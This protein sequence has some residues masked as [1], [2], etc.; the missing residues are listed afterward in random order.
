MKI[1]WIMNMA[2]PEIAEV[3]S[4]PADYGGGW[5]EQPCRQIATAHELTI[6]FPLDEELLPAAGE[7]NGIRYAAIPF[8]ASPEQLNS[9]TEQRITEIITTVNPDVIQIWGTEYLHSY[10]AFC[11][12]RKLGLLSRTLVYIQ[13]LVSVYKD[14]Y[15]GYIK[16]SS[17]RRPT[18]KDRLR[19][20]GPNLEY[21]DFFRRSPYEIEM[22][23]QTEHVI[24]RTDWDR[25]FA[26]LYHPGVH[27]HFCNETLRP[28]F[29]EGQWSLESCNRHR[30]FVSQSSYPVK[31]L[32][33]A[34]ES[35]YRLLP[36]YPDIMLYC[37]GKNRI[38]HSFHD[39]IRETRYDRYLRQ[40]IEKYQL[41]NHVVFTDKLNA[42]QMKEQYLHAHIFLSA[43]SIENSPNSVGEAM[44]LGTPVVSSDV[45]GVASMLTNEQE[46][47]LYQADRVDQMMACIDRIFTD[48]Q[49]ALRLSEQARR[50]AA[51]THDPE[52]NYRQMLAIYEEVTE[53]AE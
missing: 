43:S 39:I 25:H 36:K 40:L 24:G 23:E 31:G 42:E 4:L 16:D 45:G 20:T 11:V 46:G 7:V 48:D 37:T 21:E 30:I 28:A 3:L 1:L 47:L 29:Y 15:W 17:I 13:G 32:H 38:V 6:S 49:L 9:D 26:L 52:T 51:V 12:C 5:L 10:A 53:E 14:Y 33:L 44:M 22:L 41:Q 50:R 8:V 35:V 34:L 27:Y 2:L 19:K 18:L